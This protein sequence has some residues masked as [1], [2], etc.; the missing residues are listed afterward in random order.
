M[1]LYSLSCAYQHH[2]HAGYILHGGFNFESITLLYSTLN[3]TVLSNTTAFLYV[4]LK[5]YLHNFVKSFF[6]FH[7]KRDHDIRYTVIEI[8]CVKISNPNVC[9]LHYVRAN[10]NSK[11]NISY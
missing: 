8:Y 3:W 9:G 7:K 6:I 1:K 10:Q 5:F 11:A 2:V 4:T